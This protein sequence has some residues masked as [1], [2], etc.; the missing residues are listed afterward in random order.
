MITLVAGSHPPQSRKTKN[1]MKN[2]PCL[3]PVGRG[4]EDG[5]GTF[6]DHFESLPMLISHINF[7]KF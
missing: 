1:V 6:T 5:V 3:K 2:S 4:G 7:R